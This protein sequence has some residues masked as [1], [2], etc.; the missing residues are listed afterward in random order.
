MAGF[1]T[2]I[3]NFSKMKI[4][5]LFFFMFASATKSFAMSRIFR[6][7][8]RNDILSRGQKNK[9]GGGFRGLNSVLNM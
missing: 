6:Y 7:G 1:Q 5:D 8:L 2:H 3:S 9:A 4:L